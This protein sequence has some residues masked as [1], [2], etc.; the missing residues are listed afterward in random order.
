VVDIDNRN[1][2]AKMIPLYQR[3]AMKGTRAPMHAIKRFVAD[4]VLPLSV[5]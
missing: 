2:S 1:A 4:R 3:A 5:E